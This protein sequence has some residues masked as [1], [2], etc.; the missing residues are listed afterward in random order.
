MSD[1]GGLVDEGEDIEVL[2]MGFDTALEMVASGGIRDA[3]TIVLLQ[4]LRLKG[5]L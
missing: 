3:K 1:G 2:E 4:H 5:I